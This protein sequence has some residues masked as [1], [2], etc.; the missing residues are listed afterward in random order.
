MRRL[1]RTHEH[2]TVNLLFSTLVFWIAARLYLIPRLNEL[3][4]RTIQGES[5]RAGVK[6]APGAAVRG[7][8]AG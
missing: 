1:D 4:P 5:A 3:E 8:A 6:A 7:R 2:P